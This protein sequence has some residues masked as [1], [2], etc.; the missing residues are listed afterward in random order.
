MVAGTTTANVLGLTNGTS[1]TFT[2]H[3]TNIVGSGDESAASLAVIPAGPPLPPSGVT[4]F[5]QDR[6]AY[7][8]W[9]PGGNNGAPIT[10]YR[11]T[12]APGGRSVTSNTS[13][14]TLTGLTSGANY[15]FTVTATN[16]AGT[17]VP[18]APSNMTTVAGPPGAATNV[19]AVPGN[20]SATV[21]WTAPSSGGNPG[22]LNYVVTADPSGRSVL[23]AATTTAMIDQLDGSTQYRFTVVARNSYG[24][25]PAS[26]ASEWITPN[27]GGSS[28]GQGIPDAPANVNAAVGHSGAVI[29]WTPVAERDGSPIRGYNILI[30]PNCAGCTE[31]LTG[32]GLDPSPSFRLTGLTNGVGY[33]YR[34]KAVSAAGSG[35]FS[36]PTEPIIPV[37]PVRVMT[38]NL[39]RGL[40]PGGDISTI[41][42]MTSRFRDLIRDKGAD[43]VG[44]QEITYEMATEIAGGLGWGTPAYI[45]V[46]RPC[47]E[48]FIP[49]SCKPF[50]DAIIS[51]YP[52][53]NIDSWRLPV[54]PREAGAEDRSFIRAE[55]RVSGSTLTVYDTHLATLASDEERTPQAQAIINQ[56]TQD[57]LASSGP[58]R[59]IVVGDFN[60]RPP[61]P[62]CQSCASPINVMKTQFLDVWAALRGSEDGFT[63]NS[64]TG[65][66]RRIDYIFT[67]S[68]TGIMEVSSI[69]V[70]TT[71][72]SD[73]ASVIADL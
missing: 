46:K 40:V 15:T 24:S 45:K 18:S 61:A 71:P 27:G 43:I 52:L 22:S 37:D 23:V 55:V 29:S 14:A 21:T 73:H 68:S 70:D 67:D 1:Y 53:Q 38:W 44:F 62:D 7:V 57:R 69:M 49:Y 59:A 63:S 51:R 48:P 41:N 35:P 26:A 33:S 56:V 66:Y 20:G 60:S 47:P 5:G 13:S 58:F 8:Y 54:A 17:S 19:H 25:G 72:E 11:V 4:A 64:E 6:S 65:L 3:A 50:G 28:G 36:M 34:V 10:S 16:L 32:D 42:P 12:A 31:Y 9:N 39:K 2:V 30:T